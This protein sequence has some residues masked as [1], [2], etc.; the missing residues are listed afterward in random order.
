MT[1]GQRLGM[2]PE[3]VEG[4]CRKP[5]FPCTGAF[6]TFH[7]FTGTAQNED[8]QRVLRLVVRSRLAILWR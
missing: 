7:C 8:E 5:A 4:A 1:V 6:R 2:A 3:A